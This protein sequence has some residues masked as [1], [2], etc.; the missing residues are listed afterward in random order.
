MAAAAGAP[1]PPPPPGGPAPPG[2]HQ[3]GPGPGPLLRRVTRYRLN[4][5]L[6]MP[7]PRGTESVDALLIRYDFRAFPRRSRQPYSREEL[8][9]IAFWLQWVRAFHGMVGSDTQYILV[10]QLMYERDGYDRTLSALQT[11]FPWRGRDY[12]I[13][14]DGHPERSRRQY[15]RP[16]LPAPALDVPYGGVYAEAAPMADLGVDY[17]H[18]PRTAIDHGL[19]LRNGWLVEVRTDPPRRPHFSAWNPRTPPYLN[20][21][22]LNATIQTLR[23]YADA[24]EE[25]RRYF[26]FLATAAERESL[27]LNEQPRLFFRLRHAEATLALSE[28]MVRRRFGMIGQA[29]RWRVLA[30]YNALSVH[31]RRQV[32]ALARPAVRGILEARAPAGVNVDDLNHELAVEEAYIEAE[33]PEK[34]HGSDRADADNDD[35]AHAGRLGEEGSAAAHSTR[36]EGAQQHRHQTGDQ[37]LVQPHASSLGS[38]APAPARIERDEGATRHRH[39]AQEQQRVIQPPAPVPGPSA[40]APAHAARGETAARHGN[41]IEDQPHRNQAQD[42]PHRNQ[43]KDHRPRH[44]SEATRPQQ[45]QEQAVRSQQSLPH[46][47]HPSSLHH[48]HN[49]HNHHDNEPPQLPYLYPSASDSSARERYIAAA[50][51]AAPEPTAPIFAPSAGRLRI[52]LRL[53][54]ARG[55]AQDAPAGSATSAGPATATTGAAPT[56]GGEEAAATPTSSPGHQPGR[57]RRD[58]AANRGASAS[59]PG[60]DDPGH[61]SSDASSSSPSSPARPRARRRP[62]SPSSSSPSSGGP[63]SAPGSASPSRRAVAADDNDAD[64]AA[65]APPA[66]PANSDAV[67]R[68]NAAMPSTTRRARAAQTSQAAPGAPSG[69]PN[70]NDGPGADGP[71]A[72]AGDARTTSAA[73]SPLSS[74]GSAANAMDVDGQGDDNAQ[75]ASSSSSSSS[76]SA[77]A[78]SS[79]GGD[80]RAPGRRNDKGKA[81]MA[82]EPGTGETRP[83]VPAKRP[84]SPLASD[85]PGPGGRTGPPS[86]P[87]SSGNGAAAA[88]EAQALPAPPRGYLQ[89]RLYVP[90]RR[91]G[92]PGTWT[93]IPG[94]FVAAPPEPPAKRRLR[95]G[96]GSALEWP[97][98]RMPCGYGGE[99]A[100]WEEWGVEHVVRRGS[101]AEMMGEGKV[102][103]TRVRREVLDFRSGERVVLGEAEGFRRVGRRAVD[104]LEEGEEDVEEMVLLE[105][106]ER[107]GEEVGRKIGVKGKGEKKAGGGEDDDGDEEDSE[108][109]DRDEGPAVPSARRPRGGRARGRGSR[110]GRGGRGTSRGR[111]GAKRSGRGA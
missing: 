94:K 69:A 30:G 21:E 4:L 20:M 11:G 78:P 99:G 96:D 81:R 52:R 37:R 82:D 64:N 19:A 39:R 110:G 84:A 8:D 57:H 50:N 75:D 66:A 10:S 97:G 105:E 71:A 23:S 22:S 111:G 101:G 42:Q 16:E 74:A 14:N 109:D 100:A 68:A 77:S 73:S 72:G 24:C 65:V 62:S 95:L 46:H 67:G 17:T 32:D 107:R 6:P 51:R 28:R 108:D 9:A 56:T 93:P 55:G 80:A 29:E 85:R 106:E 33:F 59:G 104:R 44:Q 15:R 76:A 47:L 103:V 26:N 54:T 91:P 7:D 2:G 5:D 102:L 53:P 70:T 40:L 61:D 41:Q 45:V 79:D 18:G 25:V 49:H 63:G 1:P 83:L 12:A 98:K 27:N 58:Q 48:N 89:A 31:L 36:G 87:P 43:P 3:V 38:E 35:E 88:T 90:P 13:R 60:P 86:S 92:S 34:A